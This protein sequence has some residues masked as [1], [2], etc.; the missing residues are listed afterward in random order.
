M[1]LKVRNHI[2]QSKYT[3]GLRTLLCLLVSLLFQLYSHVVCS[4]Q[5]LPWVLLLRAT[6][7][8]EEREKMKQ[9]REEKSSLGPSPA[10]YKPPCAITNLMRIVHSYL[11]CLP[12]RN[13]EFHPN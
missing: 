4:M 13:H 9:G 3:K 8:V 11:L 7:E 1:V 12:L 10:I 6:K 2:Y 5:N